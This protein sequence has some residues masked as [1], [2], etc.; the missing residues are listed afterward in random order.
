M[1]AAVYE[2]F[3]GAEKIQITTVN[4]PEVKEGEVLVR[5]RAAG[6]NPVDAAVREGYLKDYLP[7]QFP[8]IPGWDMAGVVE[9]TGFSARRFELGDEVYAY[10]RR[11]V[12]QH[13]T[14]AEYIVIPE[15]YLAKKPQNLS[16]EEAAGIPLV[17]LTAYQSL[18][19]AGKLQENQTVLILG[20]SGGVGSLGI[21]LAKARG[22]TVIGVASEKNQDFMKEL[23]ADFTVDYKSQDIGAAAKAIAPDGVDLIFDCAGGDTL[24]QSLAALRPGGKLVS[25]LHHG[26]GLAPSI[27]FKYVFVEPNAS[28]LDR[29]REYAE[30]GQLQVHVSKT[31]SLAETAEALSQIQSQ[32][33]RGKT[34]I[35]P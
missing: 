28:Q 20:G 14:F 15:S 17:G 26:E 5:I 18:F 25:I 22:A 9:E 6:V 19:D 21:Q 29:L 11:P 27:D 35:V 23:G 2:G 33:T 12:V 1:K 13:G 10:A 3:G 4:V 8:I 32:H 16:F 30:S 31:Y 34:V 24:Q 7:Y